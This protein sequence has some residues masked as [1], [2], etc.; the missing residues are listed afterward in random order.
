MK[1]LKSYR[2]S[3][4]LTTFGIGAII[5]IGDESFINTG[6]TDPD[7]Q[8]HIIFPRLERRLRVSSLRYPKEQYAWRDTVKVNIGNK[9]SFRRFPSWMFCPSCRMMKFITPSISNDLN[10]KVPNCSN[11]D[12]KGKGKTRLQPMR[13]VIACE[14]GHLDEFPWKFWAHSRQNENIAEMGNCQQDKLFFNVK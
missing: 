13:F 2:M 1:D 10:G 12:C 5:G 7:N 11:N 9:F 8:N 14:H 4:G 6:V 3:Q